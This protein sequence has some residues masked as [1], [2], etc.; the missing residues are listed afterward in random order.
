MNHNIHK[1][2]VVV[3]AA[4]PLFILP[5]RIS[6]GQLNDPVN[7]IGSET[8]IF[9][10]SLTCWYCINFVQRK[11]GAWQAL[12]ISV[13]CCCVLSN[14]FY[15]TFNPLFKDFPFRTEQNSLVIK[16]LMLSSRGILMSVILIPTAYFLKR[17]QQARYQR[18]ENERLAVERVKVENRLLEQAVVDR[19]KALHEALASLET[20]QRDQEHQLYIQS[21]LMASISHDIIGPFNHM[22]I[23]CSMVREMLS[24][25]QYAQAG[26]YSAELHK[27]METMF[28]FIRNLLEFAKLPVQ[29]KLAKIETIN[30]SELINS[31]TELFEAIIKTNGNS[32][33]VE[34]DRSLHVSSN[35]ALLGIVLHNLIDNANKHTSGG[36]IRIRAFL[37]E[38]QP[39]LIC[40]NTNAHIPPEV[41]EWI[42]SDI[43]AAQTILSPVMI[44]NL[45]IGLI[46]VKEITSLLKIPLSMTYT[47]NTISARLTFESAER[48]AFC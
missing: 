33:L 27:S 28:V 14:L 16:I 5:A 21:R 41:L 18:L 30:L 35:P 47:G 9:L 24:S 11:M 31:K 15:F 34:S 37:Q 8:V 1:A 2:G 42:N 17:D 39:H 40:E 32:L 44:E 45:G 19:T 13:L 43:H 4:I 25:Q 48:H 23:I 29:Q 12:L 22:V 26:R 20:S 3:A 46:L 36:E 7:L 38:G 6:E 10:M